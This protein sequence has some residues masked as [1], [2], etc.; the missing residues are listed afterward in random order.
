VSKPTVLMLWLVVIVA[1]IAGVTRTRF[2]ADLS[3]F[4]PSAPTEEQAL[5][6]DL[7]RDGIAS[8]MLLVG[9][10]GGTATNRAQA[11]RAL[12]SAL[13]DSP[14]FVAASNGE[15]IGT[16]ADQTW[17]FDHRYLLSPAVTPAHFSTD[18]LHEAIAESIDM[19]ASSAGLMLKP[20]LT[21][22]PTAETLH[23]IEQ[24]SRYQTARPGLWVSRDGQRSLLLA[25]T[26]ASGA[27]TDG[28]AEAID[29]LR[30]TFALVTE[31]SRLDGLKLLISGPGVFAVNARATIKDEVA[32]LSLTGAALIIGL[33]LVIYRSPTALLLGLAPVATG[34]LVG[35][36]TVSLAFGHVHGITLGFG[37]PLIGE[38]VDYAIYYFIQRNGGDIHRFWRTIRLGVLTSVF[39]FAAL[40]LSG[41]PGLAQV[42]LFSMSGLVAAVLTTRYVIPWLTPT[43]FAIRN[44]DHFGRGLTALMAHAYVLR[45]IPLAASLLAGG[46]LWM[47]RDHLW[48]HEL[49]ALSP[50]PET[51]Q[52]LDEQLRRD[53]PAPDVRF[54]V[55][56]SGPDADTVLTQAERA[57]RVLDTLADQRII[58]GFDNPAGFLPSTTTQRARLASLPD[59]DTLR[60][61]LKA[62]TRDLPLSAD[63]LTPFVD[64]IDAARQGSPLTRADLDG[65][66]MALAVDAMLIHHRNHWRAVLPVRSPA[67]GTAINADTVRKALATAD[68]DNTAFVD[69][70]LESERLYAGYLSEART[71]AIGGVAAIV[72][73]LAVALRST[74]RLLRLALP[75]LATVLVVIGALNAFGERLTL[76]HLVG[77]L[78]VVAV[79]SNYALFFDAG[80]QRVDGQDL[81]TLA[82]LVVANLTTLAGFGILAFST[83]P[84][85]H[86]IGIVVGPGALLAL[87]FAAVMH[88]QAERRP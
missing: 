51:D 4:L 45:W 64:A 40:L 21:R 69:I 25:T 46:V 42:G 19:L 17:L 57:G 15:S 39:G 84:V 67:D 24:L 81:R 5:L 75:L 1:S 55:V 8:R 48:H 80:D 27:D 56:T 35:I 86:A 7:L 34:A 49:G 30:S 38:A 72:V 44:V 36:C 52:R 66:S 6:V 31:Q 10:E 87:L 29:T 76:L 83:V 53:L 18:G 47:H 23:V 62:A 50:V 79:G 70:K 77:M 65:T 71:A 41:F 63:K 58:G 11:S 43:T 13:R 32:R 12:A 85:L 2:T 74:R 3:A 82:S 88:P 22:D 9:I 33:L 20:I 26:T 60:T 61:R 37:I 28:Q 68:I 59:A 14:R 73:L 54:L 78:L 16:E